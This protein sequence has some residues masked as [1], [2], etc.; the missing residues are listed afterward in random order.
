MFISFMFSLPHLTKTKVMR[1]YQKKGWVPIDRK[2]NEVLELVSIIVSRP[3]RVFSFLKATKKIYNWEGM[4]P[5]WNSSETQ[6]GQP[7][8]HR[9]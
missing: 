4:D 9:W 8:N 6:E 2:K 7:H 1:N 5:Q 3:R